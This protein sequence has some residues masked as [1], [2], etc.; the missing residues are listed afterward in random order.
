MV[1]T[2]SDAEDSGIN[3]FVPEAHLLYSLNTEQRI[4]WQAQI[5]QTAAEHMAKLQEIVSVQASILKSNNGGRTPV[6]A[7]FH[8][9]EEGHFVAHCPKKDRASDGLV[10]HGTSL[11]GAQS[12]QGSTPGKAAGKACFRCQEGGNFV[13]D[14]PKKYQASDS[15]VLHGTS[16]KG[17]Q[18]HQGSTPGKAAGKACFRCQEEGHLVANC[19]KKYPLL[20]SNRDTQKQNLSPSEGKI[21][22]QTPVQFP[23]SSCAK[24]ISFICGD[25]DHSINQSSKA[26]K[27]VTRNLQ[28]PQPSNTPGQHTGSQGPCQ[29]SGQPVEGSRVNSDQSS[30]SVNTTVQSNPGVEHGAT[31]QGTLGFHRSDAANKRQQIH[32]GSVAVSPIEMFQPVWLLALVDDEMLGDLACLIAIIMEFLWRISSLPRKMELGLKHEPTRKLGHGQRE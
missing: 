8:C 3:N 17:A 28:S 7:C 5:L 4:A 30:G 13:A 26:C 16:L 32:A 2:A 15:L 22:N 31:S 20:F 25:M 21:C 9:Q 6:N 11:K 29:P 1:N 18:S 14:C 27:S 19:P 12:H 24:G 23:Q 10:P